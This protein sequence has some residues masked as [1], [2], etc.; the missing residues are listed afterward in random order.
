[1]FWGVALA[2][3]SLIP[4]VGAAL[5]WVPTAAWLLL[6][7]QIVRGIVLV[8]IGALAISLADNI[9]RPLVLSGRSSASGLIIFLG[10]LGGVSAFGFIGI[11][12][13]RSFS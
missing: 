7:G 5:V 3:C 8:A 1:M 12:L 13:G 6:S 9:L 2:F 10:L 11:V 4:M